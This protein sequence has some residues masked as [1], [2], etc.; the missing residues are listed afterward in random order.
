MKGILADTPLIYNW[1]DFNNIADACVEHAPLV[2][3]L[4]LRQRFNS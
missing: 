2:I 1:G 3:T 4:D